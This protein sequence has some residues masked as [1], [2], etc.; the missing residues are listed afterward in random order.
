MTAWPILTTTGR[1]LLLAHPALTPA[2]RAAL[3]AHWIRASHGGPPAGQGAETSRVTP[4]GQEPFSSNFWAPTQAGALETLE[5]DRFAPWVPALLA[6][7]HPVVLAPM[8]RHPGCPESVRLDVVLALAPRTREI[9]SAGAAP[10]VSRAAAEQDPDFGEG[11]TGAAFWAIVPP[12]RH[13]SLLVTV[14][15]N[16]GWSSAGLGRLCDALGTAPASLQFLTVALE[17]P[18]WVPGE[19]SA[20]LRRLEAIY[21]G[22]GGAPTWS[23]SPPPSLLTEDG[24]MGVRDRVRVLAVYHHLS[25]YE[26]TS[27]LATLARE[28]D[29]RRRRLHA[30]ILRRAVRDLLDTELGREAA[31]NAAS[32][33]A[34]GLSVGVPGASQVVGPGGP[35]LESQVVRLLRDL[36]REPL[37]ARSLWRVWPAVVRRLPGRVLQRDFGESLSALL[38]TLAPAARRHWIRPLVASSDRTVRE[39][40]VS[41]WGAADLPE[42]RGPD[43][44]AAAPPVSR[45]LR[46]S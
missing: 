35:L 8:L 31:S 44:P 36:V 26:I 34:W 18:A 19:R 32:A 29:P 42:P 24:P 27:R 7:C 39:F 14:V 20:R 2:Q 10:G 45:G 41:L 16:P 3:V 9:G 33:A 17:H 40:G 43:M 28:S 15:R 13:R 38:A 25:P 30:L 37:V 1:S 11:A 6:A 5:P 22:L 4:W 23:T 21:R 46:S 12:V